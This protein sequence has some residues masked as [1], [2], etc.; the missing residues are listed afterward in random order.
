MPAKPHGLGT[1]EYTQF[2][3]R[4][5]LGICLAPFPGAAEP[6]CGPLPGS[7]RNGHASPF[8][9]SEKAMPKTPA[10]KTDPGF[11]E[12]LKEL[13]DIVRSMESEPL[14]LEDS[15]AAYQRGVE[16]MRH[17]RET[18]AAAEQRVQVLEQDRDGER[19]T[20]FAAGEGPAS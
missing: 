7:T 11:E 10:D 5:S 4:G 2:D 18:L 9:P 12:A 16:L 1:F 14:S 6:D 19:L 20:G 3:R 13:E 15:L 17:C 8:R